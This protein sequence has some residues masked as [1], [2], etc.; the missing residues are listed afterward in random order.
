MEAYT[1]FA[2]VY[3]KFMD[4]VPYEEW[5]EYIISLLNKEGINEG[6]VLDLGCGTGNVTQLL[7]KAGYDMIGVDGSEDM[8]AIAMEKK[9]SIQNLEHDILYL[10]QDMRE[11]EL[12]GTVAAIVSICDCVNYITDPDD[13]LTVFKLVWNYLDYNGIFVFDLNS[14]YKYS[15]LLADNTF[16]ENSDDASFIWENYYDDESRI[17]EYDLTLFIKE[18]QQYTR[19]EEIHE[20]R[21]YSI[22][23]IA[24]MLKEAGLELL[25]IYDAFTEEAPSDD[26]E[27]I[28]FVAKKRE[29]Q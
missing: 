12:Y 19:Y 13:L 3:D 23:E 22:E 7:A 2:N 17:N 15:E 29:P 8:L 4:N 9:R 26:S 5:T 20:Q 18:G 25:H 6:I 28:Y 11:F 16:A 27:R 14:Q 1:T 24:E 10:C 21:S